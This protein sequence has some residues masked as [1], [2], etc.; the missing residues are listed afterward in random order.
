MPD[1]GSC[2]R[3]FDGRRSFRDGRICAARGDRRADPRKARPGR[4]SAGSDTERRQP[5]AGTAEWA[6]AGGDP[7]WTAGPPAQRHDLHSGPGRAS[8]RNGYGRARQP[9]LRPAINGCCATAIIGARISPRRSREADGAQIYRR[10]HKRGNRDTVHRTPR[11]LCDSTRCGSPT[12]A[13]RRN[14]FPCPIC[15]RSH[16]RKSMPMTM[17]AFRTRLQA[18]YGEVALTCAMA[19]LAASLS[20]LFFPYRL[21]VVG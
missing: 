20:L 3:R 9:A 4:H 13:C 10:R 18:L 17:A 7:L 19:L 8:Q 5:L 16:A 1:A 11:F 15:V 12:R 14:I 6:A 2:D 21:R